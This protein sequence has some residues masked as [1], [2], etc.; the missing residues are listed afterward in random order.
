[1][2]HPDPSPESLSPG[3]SAYAGAGHWYVALSGGMDSTVLL[4]LLWT[5]RQTHA[6]G[7]PLTAV[8]VNHQLQDQA[9]DWQAHCRGLCAELRVPLVEQRVTLDAAGDGPEA[10]ARR[11]RYAVFEQLLDTGDLLFMAHHL[12]DQVETL[13]L[14]LMRGAGLT[15]LAGMPAERALGAGRLVRPLLAQPRRAL[16]VYAEAQ[17]L[18]WVEDPSNRDTT[19]DRNFLRHEVLPLLAAR[20]PGYRETVGRA[21][22][23][24][25][26]AGDLLGRHYPVPDTR[27]SR[28]GDPGIPLAALLDCETAQAQLALRGWL[29]QQGLAMPQQVPMTEFLRQLATAAEDSRPRLACADYVLERYRDAVYLVTEGPV[30]EP[31]A[32]LPGDRLLTT[33]GELVLEATDGPGFVLSAG[34]RLELRSRQG[35]ER[36]R[37]AGQ[38]HS[39]SLKKMLQTLVVP[40]WWRPRVPLAFVDGELVDIGGLQLCEST[41]T[42]QSPG[43]GEQLWRLRWRPNSRGA[44]IEQWP[45]F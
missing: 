20:W 37:A 3:L 1:M 40:P 13:L 24:L 17:G 5:H 16:S 4:H 10:A 18:S 41:R 45:P 29:L 43:E 2:T 7:P 6:G 30:P 39:N 31:S 22:V 27:H 25:G 28:C 44:S 33:V 14:R 9:D 35:G 12:D 38:L 36:C 23:H 42:R 8:H 26:D 15:G 11:A 34:E 19:L 32:L 21:A